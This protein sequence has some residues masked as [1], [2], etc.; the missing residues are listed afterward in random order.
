MGDKENTLQGGGD[1]KKAKLSCLQKTKQKRRPSSSCFAQQKLPNLNHQAETKPKSKKK[2]KK[3][4]QMP[5]GPRFQGGRGTAHAIRVVVVV[6]GANDA[7]RRK[8]RK[9]RK[10]FNRN[11]PPPTTTTLTQSAM[12]EVPA[13]KAGR[14]PSRTRGGGGAL[15]FPLTRHPWLKAI[16]RQKNKRPSAHYTLR[17]IVAPGL[18]VPLDS[19][20]PAPLAYARLKMGRHLGDVLALAHHTTTHLIAIGIQRLL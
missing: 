20:I 3:T 19:F 2:N 10:G 8:G 13:Q 5:E 9:G 1:K 12:E 16:P 18:L 6:V 14:R 15:D 17:R 4:K 11:T 7:S